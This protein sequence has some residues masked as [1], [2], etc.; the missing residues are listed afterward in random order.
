[1]R[2]AEDDF[3]RAYDSQDFLGMYH[4]RNRMIDEAREIGI[5]EKAAIAHAIKESVDAVIHERQAAKDR[6][7]RLFNK[8]KADIENGETE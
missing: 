8:I 7:M 4:A 2:S 6:M 5:S 1:M 3:R